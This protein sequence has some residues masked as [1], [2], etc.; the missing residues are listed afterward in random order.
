MYVSDRRA[1]KAPV[2]GRRIAF[3]LAGIFLFSTARADRLVDDFEVGDW[4]AREIQCE[5][6]CWSRNKDY[7]GEVAVRDG[8]MVMGPGTTAVAPLGTL[9]GDFFVQAQGRSVGSGNLGVV[10]D[11][12]REDNSGYVGVL[13]ASGEVWEVSLWIVNPGRQRLGNAHFIDVVPDEDYVIRLDAIRLDA[14]RNRLE[15]RVWPATETMPDAPQCEAIDASLRSGRVGLVYE[16]GEPG[17]Y[18]RIESFEACELEPVHFLRGDCNADAIVDISDAVCILNWLFL[19]GARPGCVAAAD[20][21]GDA[22]ADLS[23]A[24]RVL[25][26]LFDGGP[27]PVAPFPDCGPADRTIGCAAPANCQ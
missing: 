14:T 5:P 19:G 1:M 10:A 2:F 20:T 6:I 15:L 11:A 4:E 7:P 12:T 16:V 25:Q 17:A 23:D 22:A 27:P 26:H 8:A 21:N 18:A 13:F 9:D 3:T 24:V